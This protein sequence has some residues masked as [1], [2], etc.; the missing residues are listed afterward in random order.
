MATL[1]RAVPSGTVVLYLNVIFSQRKNKRI[2][3]NY[4]LNFISQ[5]LFK[6]LRSVKSI[7]LLDVYILY[8]TL[9]TNIEGCCSVLLGSLCISIHDRWQ[10]VQRILLHQIMFY[11]LL[12]QTL[13]SSIHLFIYISIKSCLNKQ[14]SISSFIHPSMY[15][16]R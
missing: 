10:R 14:L 9:E 5:F 12:E 15:Y 2:E 13:H 4:F 1:E 16:I 11:S 6:D 8:F 3:K 7:K